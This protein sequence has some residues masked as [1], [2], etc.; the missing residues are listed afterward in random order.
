[1]AAV[2]GVAIPTLNGVWVESVDV[3]L[4]T[5]AELLDQV[6]ATRLPHCLQMRPGV[7]SKMAELAWARGM[8]REDHLTPLMVLEG[9]SRSGKGRAL[10]G[11]QVRELDPE[12]AAL[13]AKI[14]AA[15]F[16]APEELLLELTTPAVLALPGVHCY[17]GE[18]DG[19]PVTTGLGVAIDGWVGIFNIATP[20]AFRRHGY[21]AA[22]TA[23]AVDHAFDA[24]ATSA[25]LQS[26]AMGFQIYE[27]MG[28][29]TS[30]H[31]TC[32]LSPTAT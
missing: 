15:G 23:A 2:T 20:P 21:G 9:P 7:P 16:E 6:A 17:V 1:M 26:S 3:D 22:L 8:R 18:V 25:W 13:H 27:E 10:D 24:G 12:E 5:I 4:H 28:F 11:F 29:R 31:W 14:A 32:W 19:V 30:E